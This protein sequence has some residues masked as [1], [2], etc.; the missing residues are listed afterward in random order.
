MKLPAN[1][2]RQYESV[3]FLSPTPGKQIIFKEKLLL[4]WHTE[5]TDTKG[6]SKFTIQSRWRYLEND[7][8]K[9]FM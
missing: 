4:R 3:K 9:Y 5:R 6:K 7:Q 2:E 8:E 1:F